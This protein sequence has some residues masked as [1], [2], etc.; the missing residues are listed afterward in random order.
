MFCGKYNRPKALITLVRS[1][2]CRVVVSAVM[3]VLGAVLHLFEV[4]AAML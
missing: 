4:L 2:S 3:S 1:V